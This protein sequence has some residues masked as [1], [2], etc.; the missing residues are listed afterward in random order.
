[1]EQ[2]KA[3]GAPSLEGR[4]WRFEFDHFSG[5][6]SLLGWAEPFFSGAFGHL[7]LR[8]DRGLETVTTAGTWVVDSRSEEGFTC[9]LERTPGRLLFRAR[10]V[11]GALVIELGFLSGGE[12]EAP[13]VEEVA[14]LVIPAGGIWPGRKSN[15]GWRFYQNGWQCWT[16]SG[17]VDR[18]RPGDYLYPL[19]LP[20]AIKGML[21]NTATPITSDRGCFESE[22]FG[23][24]ADTEAK[25][26][27]VAGFIG[28]RR[29]L[30]QV[31]ARL[32]RG[33]EDS[34]LRAACRFEGK[35]TARG[36]VFWSEPLALLPGDLS[37]SNLE[38][39]AALLGREQ[40]VGEVRRGPAGWC[41]WYH[42]FTKISAAEV[43][44]NLGLLAGRYAHLG[45]ELVQVDDGYQPTVGDW[46][47]TNSDFAGGMKAL[48][49]EIASRGKVPGIWVA[50][51]TAT[52]KSKVFK[53]HRDWVLSSGKGKALLA[54]IN[55]LWGGRFHGLDITNPAVLDWVEEVFQNIVRCGY[56]FVKLDFLATAM[57]EG[58]RHDPSVTRAEAM[59][60]ALSLIRETVGPETY[61]LA[62]GGPALL[63]T[64]ILDIQRVSGDVAPYWR[65][66]Y[67]P[68]L[69]DRSTPGVRNCLAN[70]FTRYFLGGRLFE[71]DPDCLMVR[72]G[73]T[74]LSEDERRTLASVIS[75][76]GG[77]M[78]ISDD[79]ALWGEEEEELLAKVVPHV[80]ASP[81]VPDVWTRDL[82]RYMV[83]RLE[84]PAGT[85]D[86]ALVVNWS[87]FARTL[88]VKLS[89]LGLEPGTYHAHEF[90]TGRY[91]GLVVDSFALEKLPGH[92]VAVVRLT[93]VEERPRLVGSSIHVSQG[94]AEMKRMALTPEGLSLELSS[95][96]ERDV[97]V[98]LAL[99]R[100]VEPA[101]GHG[102]GGLS[103]RRL[104]EGV[105][106]VRLRVGGQT[107]LKLEWAD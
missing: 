7:K 5:T 15:R 101:G 51:F 87:A 17:T 46:L 20:R 19:F 97:S 43:E 10:K 55:P 72:S 9:V 24:L 82:P 12:A 39:Y 94:A 35:E 47:D 76:Y 83:S 57:L 28:V 49:G 68:F 85:Y 77:A 63:G 104:A 98:T 62:A 66:R 70:I 23:G 74:R 45:V 96:V 102:S 4:G 69:R 106:Q 8:G 21:A 95:P 2:G 32:G 3:A 58:E 71:G 81:R 48:A 84:D 90:W 105:F 100:P 61:L 31:S 13:A 41:S 53:E 6:F 56:R 30:S 80:P 40:G 88:E 65:A 22:W 99:P 103:V 33:R 78:L 93:P 26:S 73:Q 75:V 16:P 89:E 60:R 25:D 54:G 107:E 92:G 50:P 14:P 18:R 36:E 11:G 44:K 29:A 27:I 59:H 86:N 38:E 67:Q 1:M 91:L 42:Y 52:R 37:G 64:G 79:L 34:E